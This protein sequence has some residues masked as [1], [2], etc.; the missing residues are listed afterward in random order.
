MQAGWGG[1][2]NNKQAQVLVVE[3]E[4]AI[5]E[6]IQFAL[7]RAGMDV[8]GAADAREALSQISENKPDI[9]LMDWMMPG[10]SGIELTR[11]LR[12]EPVTRD[13]PI[14]MLTA[15]VTED[16]KVAGP[17]SGNRR[18]RDQAVLAARTDRAHQRGVAAHQP[19][20]QRRPDHR[21]RTAAWTRFRAA[22]WPMARKWPWGLPNTAC[23]NFS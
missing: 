2:V 17:G 18:L 4:T 23:W 9:I 5:R 3:D 10:V 6:M 22:S 13:I 20:R 1:I 19:G 11:R 15:K 8:A 12:R 16:D 14:I 21:R 7:R